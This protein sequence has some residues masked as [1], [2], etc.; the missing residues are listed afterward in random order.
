MSDYQWHIRRIGEKPRGPVNSTQ[1]I[2]MLKKGSIG[3]SD[4][5]SSEFTKGEW[6]AVTDV[7]ALSEFV[8]DQPK[9]TN[10][11]DR[12]RSQE[13]RPKT[14]T[15]RIANYFDSK[16][17]AQKFVKTCE[18]FIL[19]IRIGGWI[20]LVLLLISHV[21]SSMARSAWLLETDPAKAANAGTEALFVAFAIILGGFLLIEAQ[22][23]F[24]RFLRIVVVLLIDMRS[25][26]RR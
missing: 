2:A 20:S 24:L 25:E 15:G 1:L 17:S 11:V 26:A 12:Y 22:A 4:F 10:R 13:N 18:L 5:V 14:T 21:F 23:L 8:S 16:E 19:L 7:A 6:R 3:A 9:A